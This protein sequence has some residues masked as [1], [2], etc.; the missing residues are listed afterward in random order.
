MPS[1]MEG[2][3]AKTYKA[4][5]YY[6]HPV[7]SPIPKI[8]TVFHEIKAG[9]VSAGKIRVSDVGSDVVEYL[10]FSGGRVVEMSLGFG[11]LLAATNNQVK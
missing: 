10:D 3:N 9:L 11:Y 6:S 5:E 4:R 2:G 8:V 7:C 1:H